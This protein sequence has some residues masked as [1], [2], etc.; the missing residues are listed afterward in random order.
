MVCTYQGSCR[1]SDLKAQLNK[2]VGGRGRESECQP[3][4]VE[5]LVRFL[6][7]PEHEQDDIVIVVV[8]IHEILE[9]IGHH[10]CKPTA[11]HARAFEFRKMTNIA[12][13]VLG[14]FH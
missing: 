3:V 14:D 9:H 12:A 7:G 5:D 10:N 2:L 11:L 6:E 8:D 1:L 13:F 4:V